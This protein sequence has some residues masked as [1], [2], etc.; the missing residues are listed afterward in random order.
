M[1]SKE[2]P[3]KILIVGTVTI[4]DGMTVEEVNA[5]GDKASAARAA[6]RKENK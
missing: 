5:A 3:D 1:N 6:Q 4:P 2:K